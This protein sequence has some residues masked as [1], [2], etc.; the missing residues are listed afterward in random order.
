MRIKSKNIIKFIL[1]AIGIILIVIWGVI[2]I[3]IPIILTSSVGGSDT[4]TS[5][6]D[7]FTIEEYKVYLDVLENNKVNVT[8]DITVDW[9]NTNHH[10]ILKFIPEWL[11]YTD[12]NGNTIKR[13][14]NIKD[15]KSS[16]DTYSVDTVNGKTRIKLGNVNYYVDSGL[17]TYSISYLYD[18]GND[19]YRGFDE[20]IFHTFGDYWGTSIKNASIEVKMPKSIE[21]MNI[22][23]FTDKYRKNN[24]NNMVN[25][26]VKDN[27]LYV[28]VNGS[29]N[30]SLTVDIELP[31]HYFKGGSY[32]YGFGSLIFLGAVFALTFYTYLKWKKYGKDYPKQPETVEI[33]PPD[34]LNA[35]QIGYVYGTSNSKLV[36]GLIVELASKGYIKI[37]E[38]NDEEENIEI[39]NLYPKPVEPEASGIVSKRTI[40]IKKLKKYDKTLSKNAIVMMKYLFKKGDTKDLRANIDAF[41]KVRDELE[42]GSFIEVVSDNETEREKEILTAK[43]EYLLKKH[44]YDTKLKERNELVSK[45]KP[46]SE[47]EELVYNKLFE[48]E[49]DI[50]LSEHKTL[51]QAFNSIYSILKSDMKPLIEDNNLNRTINSIA[52]CIGNFII[53]IFSYFVIEDMDPKLSFLYFLGL[54][55]CF[56]TVFFTIIMDRKTAYGETL[57]AK[58]QGFR[59][60]LS[61]VEKDQLE[62]M[63][64][65]NPTYFYDILPFTYVLGIS[66]K[67]ISKFEN[68][69]MP[70][71]DMGNFNYGSDAFYSS[72]ASDIYYPVSTGGGS[73]SGGGCSSCGGGCSSCGGGCSSCG[74][75]GSW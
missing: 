66:K 12:K 42:K 45:L 11:E 40:Q 55:C 58:V 31:N 29:L 19:P 14:A 54:I 41:F 56:V 52:V 9:Y 51:Y 67:W 32:T 5:T 75:G 59:D 61:L 33:Y 16:S 73:S 25:Y 27:T 65:K 34:N 49:D 74:G 1:K 17:K 64:S 13:K 48:S 35:A 68:I 15:L 38:L 62:S 3:G 69:K 36:I 24:V 57:E 2:I 71:I 37:N 6:A 21:G 72:F 60:Y 26:Q 10:G 43:K 20:F 47:M 4:T 18:M 63:V 44:E 53:L 70:E 30:S 22:N 23:F 8:E 28:K 39:I 7:G 46:L 50:I